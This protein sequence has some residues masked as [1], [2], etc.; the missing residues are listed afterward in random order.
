MLP[1]FFIKEIKVRIAVIGAGWFGCHIAACLIKKGIEVIIYD[2]GESVFSGASQFNTGRLHLGFHYARSAKT[3][4]QSRDGFKSF[5][6]SYASFCEDV[7]PNLY[8]ISAKDS[9]IDF[10]TY[11]SILNYEKYEFKVIEPKTYNLANME[12]GFL[13]H[14]KAI[15]HLKAAEYF[16]AILKSNLMLNNPVNLLQEND[17][18]VIINGKKFDYCINCTYYTFSPGKYFS[19]IVY[20]TVVTLLFEPTCLF[21]PKAFV[22]MDGNFY[23]LNPYFTPAGKTIYSIYHVTDSVVNRHTSFDAALQKETELKKLP[24]DKQLNLVDSMEHILY[25]YPSFCDEFK[26]A[27]SFVS[28]RTKL[29]NNNA[30]RECIVEQSGRVISVLSGKVNSIFEAEEEVSKMLQW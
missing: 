28:T 24:V 23:S 8:L 29:I 15:N 7:N 21:K 18:A 16:K 17:N 27:G 11:V 30:N 22:I 4:A 26:L 13:C 12:G 3:R 19:G 14:E 2:K 6:Q 9:L 10:D 5:I 1:N 25:F 20:E